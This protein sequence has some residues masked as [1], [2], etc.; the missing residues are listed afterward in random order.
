[1]A[2]NLSKTVGRNISKNV[3]GKY[4]QKDL[5]HAKQSATDKLESNSKK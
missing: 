1:M 3:Y 4:S 5:D 2:I